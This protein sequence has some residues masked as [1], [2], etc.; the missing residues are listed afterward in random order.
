MTIAIPQLNI[1]DQAY[2]LID[3]L[4]EI[5]YRKHYEQIISTIL[6]IAAWIV[7]IA[8]TIYKGWQFAAPHIINSA[9]R[10]ADFIESLDDSPPPVPLI[11]KIDKIPF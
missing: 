7:V 9:R 1:Q 10:L 5:N 6:L 4:K 2:S 11:R 3:T 8:Q